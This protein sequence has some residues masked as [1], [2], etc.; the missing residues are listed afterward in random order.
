MLKGLVAVFMFFALPCLSA[1]AGQAMQRFQQEDAAVLRAVLNTQCQAKD[2]YVLLSSQTVGPRETDDMGELDDSG[3]FAD[4]K[5]R[6]SS[7]VSLPDNLTCKGARLHREQ[8][9][10]RAFDQESLGGGNVALDEAWKK[11]FESFPGAT[12]WTSVSVPGYS[13]EGDIAV[14]YVAHHCGSLCGQGSY[15]YLHRVNDQWKILV[16]FPIWVS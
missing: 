9:I 1:Q 16:R 11:L 10:K 3:A 4:M 14:V 6:N 2:G 8:D 7:A 13:P 5:R 15:L 12:G